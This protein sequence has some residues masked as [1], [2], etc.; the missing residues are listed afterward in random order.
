MMYNQSYTNQNVDCVLIE[1]THIVVTVVIW[2]A[3]LRIIEY[4]I[5]SSTL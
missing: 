2:T 3:K 5:L 1:L 4:L